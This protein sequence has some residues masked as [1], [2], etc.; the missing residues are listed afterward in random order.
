MPE[1]IY[2]STNDGYQMSGLNVS[3]D[4]CHDSVG[5]SNPDINNTRDTTN[6]VRYEYVTGRGAV[7][8]FLVRSFFDFDTSAIDIKPSA[9]SFYFTSYS[10]AAAT[11]CIIAKSGHDPSTA[12][13]DWFSTWLTDQDPSITLSGWDENDVTAYSESTAL[14]SAGSTTSFTLLDAGLND[15]RDLDSFKICLLHINDYNDT[16]PTSGLLRTGMHWSEHG[17]DAERPLITYTA[18]VTVT[19]NAVFFGTN[20]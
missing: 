1:V 13:D 19:D 4:D 18:A 9:A 20:F 5:L 6:G 2:P 3:W 17:T 12:T 8:F 16:A 15:M 14:A 7:Q 10:N 11:P